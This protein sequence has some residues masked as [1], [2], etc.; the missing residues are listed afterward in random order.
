MNKAMK[1]LAFALQGHVKTLKLAGRNDGLV[2]DMER[3]VAALAQSAVQG[4]P[5]LW[6][7]KHISSDTWE[8]V[9]PRIPWKHTLDDKLAEL[10]AYTYKGKPCY[11]VRALYAHPPPQPDAVQSQDVGNEY[12][13]LDCPHC[14]RT[15]HAIRC[16]KC[17]RYENGSRPCPNGD[18]N[19]PIVFTFRGSIQL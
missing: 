12:V 8:D 16:A 2:E 18:A 11:E 3:A 5:V 15:I 17:G 4:E 13:I 1:P 10:R 6:Q 14:L 7:Y 9:L 19:C